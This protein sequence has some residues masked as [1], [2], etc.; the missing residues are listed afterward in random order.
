MKEKVVLGIFFLSGWH[1]FSTCLPRLYHYVAEPKTWTE[2]QS[3]CREKYTDLATI[4]NMEEMNQ[5]INTVP[6]SDYYEDVWIGL[7]DDWRWS[8]SDVSYYTDGGPDYRNWDTWTDNEPDFG[9]GQF[10]VNVGDNG[11][12]WDDGCTLNYPFI[13]YKGTT[14]DPKFVVVNDRMNW[15]SA[16]R[17]CRENYIDLAS[18][19]NQNENQEIQKLVPRGDWAWIG[20]YRGPLSRWSDGSNS[21]F[22]YWEKTPIPMANKI[23]CA[24]ALR[25]SF[26]WRAVPCTNRYPFVCYS[27]PVQ[28]K[29]VFKLK[30]KLEDSSVDLNDPAVKADILLKFQD[31]L[32]DQ[33]VTGVVLKWRQQPDGKV[34]HKEEKS[35]E[36][37]EKKKPQKKSEL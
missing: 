28:M 5:L 7:H 29:Q 25:K 2:A 21:S 10:C 20:L 16:Q 22:T 34:F 14:M 24:A 32:K 4:D 15:S 11:G 17:Y 8:F 12:W 26:K 18:V 37:K 27:V 23:Q 9:N 30:V 3:Y 6:S 13:C 33:G 36:K 1:T 35:P 19:R 31:R